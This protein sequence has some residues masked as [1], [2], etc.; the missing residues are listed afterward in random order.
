MSRIMQHIS[1]RRQAYL[2]NSMVLPRGAAEAMSD[3]AAETAAVKA[4]WQQHRSMS[5]IRYLI[6]GTVPGNY[7]PLENLTLP[8]AVVKLRIASYGAIDYSALEA[9]VTFMA[10]PCLVLFLFLQRSY[11]RGFMSGALR[12]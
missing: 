12:G 7:P 1:E 4:I 2:I 3:G 10:V 8:L 11:V 5:C 6:G 9:G